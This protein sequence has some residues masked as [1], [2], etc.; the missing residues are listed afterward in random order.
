M[1]YL[2]D[3]DICIYW[4]KNREP[5]RTKVFQIG[6]GNIAI[7]QITVA[8]LYYGA[9]NGRQERIEVN[10]ERVERFIKSLKVLELNQSVLCE[11]GQLKSLLRKQ[12]RVVADFDLL[13]ASCVIAQDLTLFTNNIR[14][15]RYIP[16]LKLETTI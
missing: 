9:Y 16:K 5:F 1:S 13:I 12:G 2:L 11:F 3:T 4:L 10:L 8:E 7:S 15:Y 6:W 14:H